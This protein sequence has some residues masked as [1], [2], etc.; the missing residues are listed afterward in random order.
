ML[1]GP[2]L[3]GS[4]FSFEG[5]DGIKGLF[6][7]ASMR[8]LHVKVVGHSSPQNANRSEAR[9][10]LKRANKA[11]FKACRTGPEVLAGQNR[12][13]MYIIADVLCTLCPWLG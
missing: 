2:C 11:R 12:H 13:R 9:T 10:R 8:M 4:L 1:S 5:A 6:V 7:S 3:Y